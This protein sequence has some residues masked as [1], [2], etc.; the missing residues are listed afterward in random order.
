MIN[1]QARERL[2]PMLAALDRELPAGYSA[3]VYGS[4]VRGDYVPDRSDVNVL[5]VMETL[6][7]AVVRAIGRGVTP[8]GTASPP[9]LLT[10]REWA[11]TTDTFP[12]EITDMRLAYDMARGADLLAGL[13]VDPADLRRALEREVRG[14]V[15]RLRQGYAGLAEDPEGL[16]ALVRAG[17]PTLEL[18][19]RCSL[20]LLDR[21]QGSSAEATLRSAADALGVEA[22]PFLMVRA[23]RLDSTMTVD[24]SGIE[25]LLDVLERV[26]EIL[27]SHSPGG[28]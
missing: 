26:A 14:K 12:L 27:D 2:D 13:E 9:L 25:K 4:A 17:A 10:R 15:I 16:G 21:P 28:T 11:R 3:L 24:G 19:A 8:L 1:A 22:E 18:V 5:L 7:P 20:V 6:S 23:A